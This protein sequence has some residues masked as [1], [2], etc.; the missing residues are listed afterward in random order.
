MLGPL[1]RGGLVGCEAPLVRRGLAGFGAGAADSPS[2]MGGGVFFFRACASF[3]RARLS[4]FARF[5]IIRRLAPRQSCSLRDVYMLISQSRPAT[6]QA[7]PAA[8]LQSR[9]K[10]RGAT[11]FEVWVMGSRGFNEG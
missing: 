11:C 4:S 7:G 8:K 3:P 5:S 1:G 9:L 2:R 6:G 10:C